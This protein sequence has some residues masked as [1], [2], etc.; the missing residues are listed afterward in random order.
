V[1]L[2]GGSVLAFFEPLAYRIAGHAEGARQAPQARTLFVS[3]QNL[4][5]A[6]FWV[7]FRTW[8]LPARSA[9]AF[10][11]IFLLAIRS[12]AVLDYPVAAT[13]SAFNNLGDHPLS[14]QPLMSHYLTLLPMTASEVG[15]C[16]SEAV[17]LSVWVWLNLDKGRCARLRR[18]PSARL[19]ASSPAP[20]GGFA[21]C[22]RFR[23]ARWPPP[24]GVWS[25][26]CRPYPRAALRR[27]RW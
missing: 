5:F 10:A 8:I 24:R 14:Y 23:C 17:G 18:R 13:V 19:G 4:F 16:T 3:P 1:L 9:T 2:K 6:C 27:R 21:R 25:R 7:A 22:G 20:R 26:R 15:A 11:L 12:L